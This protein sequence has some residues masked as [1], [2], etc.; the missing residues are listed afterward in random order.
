MKT[1]MKSPRSFLRSRAR[2]DG[3]TLIEIM[4]VVAVIALIAAIAVPS[5]IQARE[6]SIRTKLMEEL[7]ATADGFEMYAADNGKLPLESKTVSTAIS[8]AYIPPSGMQTY[9]PKNSHWPDGTD[10]T[11]YWVYWTGALPGYEGFLYLYNPGLTTDDITFLD[12][13]FDDGNPN[14]GALINYG[15][16]GSIYA[17]E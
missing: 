1:R 8:L 7:K 4:I 6:T 13:K 2:R 10:G 15:G 12:Q 11:R 5:M 14:T 3:F 16:T 17:V 9:L